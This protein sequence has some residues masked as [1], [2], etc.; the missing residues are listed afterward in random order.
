MPFVMSKNRNDTGYFLNTSDNKK[1]IMTK[2]NYKSLDPSQGY[3]HVNGIRTVGILV[4][5]L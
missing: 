2:C 5:L 4:K 1:K 3:F